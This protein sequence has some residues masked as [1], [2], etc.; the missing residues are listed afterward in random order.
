MATIHDF[1]PGILRAGERLRAE[2]YERLWAEALPQDPELIDAIPDATRAQFIFERTG[3]PP[4]EWEKLSIPDGRL[5]WLE[6]AMAAQPAEPTPVVPLEFIAPK[7]VVFDGRKEMTQPIPWRLMKYMAYRE[8]A[9]ESEL[10]DLSDV[11][12]EIPSTRAIT[13]AVNRAGEVLLKL[14]SGL[15]LRRKDGFIFWES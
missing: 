4:S 13:N 3:L 15:Q 14:E 6:K 12:G 7:T 9:A 10:S 8:S 2:H 5:P 11:W 1:M